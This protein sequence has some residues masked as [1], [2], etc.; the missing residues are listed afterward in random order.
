MT[1]LK[2]LST[3][4]QF[5]HNKLTRYGYLF[6]LVFI[7]ASSCAI[8]RTNKVDIQQP[9]KGTFQI[10]KLE[11][12]SFQESF[13]DSGYYI[14][15]HEHSI[16][17]FIGCNR[18][19]GPFRQN[20]TLISIEALLSTKKYCRNMAARELSF[21]HALELTTHFSQE[22]NQFVLIGDS[23]AIYLLQK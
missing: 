8:T 18:I 6:M 3:I 12:K 13:S 11:H 5:M 10:L 21:I 17:A 2:P 7:L 1:T 15:I 20:D 19:A 16:N 4:K 23:S 14:D 9:L 22:N